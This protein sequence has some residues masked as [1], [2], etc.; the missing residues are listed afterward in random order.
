MTEVFQTF[1]HACLIEYHTTLNEFFCENGIPV[2]TNGKPADE[3]KDS[4]IRNVICLLHLD[5]LRYT[6]KQALIF[7]FLYKRLLR[8][9]EWRYNALV[10]FGSYYELEKQK[11]TDVA[12]IISAVDEFRRKTDLLPYKDSWSMD[13]TLYFQYLFR[14][15]LDNGIFDPVK[16]WNFNAAAYDL[17]NKKRKK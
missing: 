8:Y 3:E 6:P 16:A 11:Q 4:L 15:R 12:K 2:L 17:K 10:D 5:S 14:D 1:C 9:Y 7:L 13:I